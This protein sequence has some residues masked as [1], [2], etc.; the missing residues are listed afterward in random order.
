M[1]STASTKERACGGQAQGTSTAAEQAVEKETFPASKRVGVKEA[2]AS[3]H[4]IAGSE[5]RKLS[6]RSQG[7]GSGE[8]KTIDVN[9]RS[10]E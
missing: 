8:V 2:R 7:I 5:E 9:A 4:F 1:A 10:M 3:Q 6:L